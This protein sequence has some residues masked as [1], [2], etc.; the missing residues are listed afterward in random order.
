MRKCVVFAATLLLFVMV[1]CKQDYLN[2]TEA[3]TIWNVDTRADKNP[4]D[5][6]DFSALDTAYFVSD[7]DVEA[8]I[9]F[10]Q[11]LAEGQGKDF[12][13][14]E[15]VP[16]GLNDEATLAYL[17]NYNEGWEIIAADKRA[18]IVLASDETGSFSL[19]EVPDNMM[20]WI[21]CL[22]A[23]VLCLRICNDRPVWADDEVWV[24]M[25]SSIDFWLAINANGVFI[26]RE[27]GRTRN[28]PPVTGYWQLVA[29]YV[30]NADTTTY[31]HLITAPYSSFHQES[32]YNKYCPKES[33]GSTNHAP[34]GCVAVAGGM[35]LGYLHNKI[36]YPIQGVAYAYFSGTVSSPLPFYYHLTNT[37]NIW[38][39]MN[40][41]LAAGLLA[42][43]GHQTNMSYSMSESTTST[44][45]LVNNI[46]GYFNI[47]C[48]YGSFS[49]SVINNSLQNEMPVIV[50]AHGSYHQDWLGNNYYENGH[51]FIIDSYRKVQYTYMYVYEWV[52]VIGGP[53]PEIEDRIEIVMPS[54]IVTDYRMR[55]GAQGNSF[56]SNWFTPTGNWEV[57]D[58]YGDTLNFIYNRYMINGFSV[59]E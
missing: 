23:D 52:Y 26:A 32:P 19:E 7:K 5:E 34:A 6:I 53:E 58:I 4:L 25:L 43:I 10:K 13:V 51:A 12:E 57:Q 40:N 39:N 45:S 56:D 42:F 36:G 41:D 9:H 3:S 11:L 35:M 59:Y 20:A 33:I 24:K 17:L 18:P 16:M 21:E 22:E 15:V 49:T 28:P 30:V 37:S 8:Y 46:F 50:R 47:S 55:W 38:G 31:S 14:L 54:P 48:T 29:T 1:S 44:N 2:P 27:M